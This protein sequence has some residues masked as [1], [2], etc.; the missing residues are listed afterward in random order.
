[1]LSRS[2]SAAI[3]VNSRSALSSVIV[4]K[5][6]NSSGG[7]DDAK[8][9]PSRKNEVK[10][11]YNTYSEFMKTQRLNENG[12]F[13][14]E[15]ISE[16]D[17]ENSELA[18]YLTKV[19]A[20]KNNSIETK[21][22]EL[23][24]AHNLSTEELKKKF[25]EKVAL[26]RE[27]IKSSNEAIADK[28]N[29]FVAKLSS[30]ATGK[31]ALI[32]DLLDALLPFAQDL[33]KS[34]AFEYI[35]NIDPAFAKAFGNVIRTEPTE[36][37][38]QAMTDAFKNGPI[39]QITDEQY[40]E[41]KQ[42]LDG[43]LPTQQEKL[44]IEQTES[45]ADE[46]TSEIEEQPIDGL[47]VLETIFSNLNSY[48]DINNSP[49][50]KLIEQID[51]D[52]AALLKGYETIDPTDETALKEKYEEIFNYCSDKNSKIYKAFGDSNSA[53]FLKVKKVLE[54][55]LPIDLSELYE[56]FEFH[57][58][59]F[60]SPLFAAIQQVDPIFANLLQELE[61]LP[62]GDEL[63]AKN[64]EIDAYLV[65]KETAIYK[66]MNDITSD[67][68][69]NLRSTLNLEW[70]TIQNTVTPDKLVE[71]SIT[72]G[73]ESD[74]FKLISK[75][76]PEFTEFVA[77]IYNETNEEEAMK[78]YASLQE[79]LESP[80]AIIGALEDKN[81]INYKLLSDLVFGKPEEISQDVVA[82][83]EPKEV[84][85]ADSILEELLAE[86]QSK[87]PEE[88]KAI[89]ETYDLTIDVLNEIETELKNN[90][91]IPVS[92][93]VSE[94]LDKL[95]GFQPSKAQIEE[96]EQVRSSPA[97]KQKDEVL[98]L[99]VNIIMKDGK[100][101]AA[102]KYLNRALYLLF[103]ET[104]SNPVEKFKEA[105]DIVAPVVVTKTVKTGFA[106]NYTVPVPLTE[107]Q[108]N[109]M[110]LQWILKSSDSKASNDFSVRLCDEILHVLSGKSA[111]MDKRV[112]S[113][114]LA[115]ANRSYLT[116]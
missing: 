114:K 58:D 6:F 40:H 27:Q 15:R 12:E 31:N 93:Q 75:I 14:S 43:S 95:L 50:L 33:S 100:K 28:I 86:D 53:E 2:T 115:I 62:E 60:E 104:R 87:Y 106:K 10:A 41:L 5:R 83:E 23:A 67:A 72:N 59:Y 107:R 47:T 64:I 92:R 8:V 103:L 35:Y 61:T 102:R 73:L 39:S 70:E 20:E 18:K 71:Y 89:N 48:D 34:P 46:L 45:E 105:L 56:V 29:S 77:K 30:S 76:D 19:E 38:V 85:S 79:Y 17:F 36:E 69:A 3:R 78:H 101:E 49:L 98:E 66:A 4:S 113:H 94:K 22:K 90:T 108:R 55:P 116:I 68:F 82:A 99:A 16:A 7:S 37:L 57:P 32:P 63:D 97:P 91:F 110:A 11:F 25:E 96:V 42:I 13:I 54:Q 81:S 65:N 88:V 112:L 52:F 9:K 1:M 44:E 51:G 74:G 26:K 84:K 80:N 111:L 24:D 109:R 21:L